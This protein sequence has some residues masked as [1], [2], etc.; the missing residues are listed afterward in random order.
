MHIVVSGCL[1]RP[2]TLH[3]NIPPLVQTAVRTVSNSIPPHTRTLQPHIGH[4]ELGAAPLH[5]Q[6]PIVEPVCPRGPFK[7]HIQAIQ[8]CAAR[9][10]RAGVQQGHVHCE[11]ALP[12]DQWLQGWC[13]LK[14]VWCLCFAVSLQDIRGSNVCVSLN[15]ESCGS[16]IGSSLG[17]LCKA[18]SGFSMH[19]CAWGGSFITNCGVTVNMV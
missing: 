13:G 14:C 2:R 10:S 3:V 11:D 8:P 18:L 4:P 9:T 15:S 12:R 1:P 6:Q 5:K 16:R 17:V 19:A 7:S